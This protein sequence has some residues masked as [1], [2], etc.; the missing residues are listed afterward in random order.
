MKSEIRN[1]RS[2]RNP[3]A[4]SQLQNSRGLQFPRPVPLPS[5]S[6]A[7]ESGDLSKEFAVLSP[8]P[9]LEERAGERR[10]LNAASTN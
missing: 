4:E 6:T 3:K 7:I 8:S 10:P 1:P 2:E 9:P 5:G